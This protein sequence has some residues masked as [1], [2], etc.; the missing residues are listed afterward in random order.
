MDRFLE[1]WLNLG[2][3]LSLTAALCVVVCFYF[4]IFLE[5]VKAQ[6][7]EG[8]VK[9][10]GATFCK[11]LAYKSQIPRRYF[12]DCGE[13][14]C[15][16]D[17]W[18]DAL[19][20]QSAS[21]PKKE[22]VVLSY[23][24]NGFGNQLWQ[25]SVAF[26]IAESLRAKLYI[27][28]IPDDLSPN[29]YIPPNS[30]QGMSAMERMLPKEFLYELLPANSSIRRLCDEE[31]FVFADRP[32]DWRDRNYTSHF[33]QNV[34]NVV[35][36]PNPR[37]MKLVGYFQNLP[38]C[39]DDAKQLWTPN[40]F[41]NATMRPGDND[42]SIYLRCLPRHYHFNGPHFYESILNHTSFDNVWLFQAP[43]CPRKLNENPAK[44]GI[45]ASVVRVLVEKYNAKRWP[46]V[47]GTDGT[48]LLLNDLAGLALSKKLILPVSS[49]AFWGGMLSNATEI[50]VNAPP[51][52]AVMY[53]MNRYTYHNEK[54]KEYFGK[55]DAKKNDIIYKRHED[56]VNHH[57]ARLRAKSMLNTHSNINQTA[58]DTYIEQKSTANISTPAD[59]NTSSRTNAGVSDIV[60]LG[61]VNGVAQQ[62]NRT[63]LPIVYVFTVVPT[64]CDY[65]VPVYI[66]TS[67]QQSLYTQ[68]DSEVILVSNFADCNKTFD[69]V[70]SLLPGL[71]LIDSVPLT[72]SRTLLYK[73][74]SQTMFMSDGQGEL[75]LTSALRFFL[76]E[77]IMLKYD[78]QEMMHIEADNMLYGKLTS[79]L[80]V[81]REHYQ[82]LAA[83]PL[84]A[85]EI[86]ITASVFWISAREHLVTFNDFLMALGTEKNGAWLKYL[87]WIRPHSCCRK[88]GLLPDR[89]GDGIKPYAINEMSM[90]GHYHSLH[91]QGFKQFP[92]VPAGQYNL[93]RHVMNMSLF[94][95]EGPEVG[96]PT[97]HGIWD[98][99]SWGQLIGGTARKK[100]RD[101]GFTDPTHIAGQ[102]IRMS[103]DACEVKLLCGNQ[104]VS[105]Y[106]ALPPSLNSV[107]NLYKYQL[108][109]Y[110]QQPPQEQQPAPY[111]LPDADKNGMPVTAQ[112]RADFAFWDSHQETQC[113][114]APFVRFGLDRSW[115]PLW[116]L[117]VH[118]KATPEYLS[119]PC[120]CP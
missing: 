70:K 62:W 119:R 30:W 68:F 33:K 55:Y 111:V 32:I 22:R 47:E 117:H 31:S 101:K 59:S 113:Y 6:S 73:N 76:I 52:H 19:K 35:N 63:K 92:V 61:E 83:T 2:R 80:P 21:K 90:L 67:L 17:S 98:P 11:Y 43:E 77:D 53:G 95:P 27:A 5:T 20:V 110:Q 120:P 78:M 58:V 72:S 50:H 82:G 71:I 81:L 10:M 26:M 116:N 115:T 69:S 4:A 9:E 93:N 107:V 104:T 38:L 42:I 14:N 46:A 57:H 106:A 91:A 45:V 41:A 88:G 74:V 3:R 105:P 37:C 23:G 65:G 44:D 94:S 103:G 15:N 114:T 87:Q 29:G 79:L 40:L 99:N 66:K 18:T 36:D 96:A 100:G 49:W 48:A 13:P 97:G 24:H 84:T 102:A 12:N 108:S 118:S 34:L 56:L 60:N 1:N 7:L 85:R 86:M 28:I 54:T 109:R 75:W 16:W 51:F 39:A 64:L 8:I 112:Q 25:H 89:N